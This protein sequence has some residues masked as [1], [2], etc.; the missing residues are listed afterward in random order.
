M[1]GMLA[2]EA[3]PHF[4]IPGR[5]EPRELAELVNEVGLVEGACASGH[6]SAG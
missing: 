1:V 6:G 4:D 2:E 5:R 3:L